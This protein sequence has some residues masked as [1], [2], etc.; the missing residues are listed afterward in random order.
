MFA[1]LW[2]CGTGAPISIAQHGAVGGEWRQY[3]GDAGGTK[4]SP[5]DQIDATNV[6]QLQIVWRWKSENF[7]PR[8]Q[9]NW[10]VT[11]LMIGGVL[12]LTAGVSRVAAAVDATT[13]ETLWTYRLEE[14]TRGAQAPRTNN[15]GLAYWSDGA[16]DSRVLM[17]SPGYHLIALDAKTGQPTP[18]FG[19][20]GIVDLWDGLDRKVEPGQIWVILSANR[21][22]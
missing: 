7:G 6:H 11:P 18:K 13:G 3:G 21:R 4:Y 17:I 20:N 12:Y 19:V 8:P 15:R 10:Q 14:G 1:C 22:R 2:C 5:L 16:T 9:Y